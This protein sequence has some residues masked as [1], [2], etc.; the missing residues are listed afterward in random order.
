[1]KQALA[2]KF[3]ALL[4]FCSIIAVPLLPTTVAADKACG[5]GSNALTLLPAWYK[6]LTCSDSGSVKIGSGSSDLR[7]FIIKIV[8]NVIEA[9]LFIVGY[10]ALGMIIWGGFK[11][12]MYGDNPGGVEGAKKT[13]LNAIIGLII[14]IFSIVIVNLI[15]GAF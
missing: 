2:A 14:S 7:N 5:G 10:I 4:L 13:I 11:Y 9:M 8:L 3:I 12:M 15:A 6:G 1:M